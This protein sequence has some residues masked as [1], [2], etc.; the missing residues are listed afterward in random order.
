MHYR[1]VGI[2]LDKNNSLLAYCSPIDSICV[3]PFYLKS[4]NK[5]TSPISKTQTK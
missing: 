1:I 5:Y 4:D 2:I 3:T